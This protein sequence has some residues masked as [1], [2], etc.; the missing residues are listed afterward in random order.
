MVFLC[1]TERWP[2]EDI[3]ITKTFPNKYKVF[4]CDKNGIV[5]G[6]SRGSGIL[7]LKLNSIK[8]QEIPIIDIV[9]VKIMLS[10]ALEIYNI[11]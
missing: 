11:V 3:L 2:S 4:R 5:R 6:I 9:G 10:N 8:L 1:L 7:V